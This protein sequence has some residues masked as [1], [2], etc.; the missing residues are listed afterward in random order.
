MGAVVPVWATGTHEQESNAP[1]ARNS[2]DTSLKIDVSG[3]VGRKAERT[4]DQSRRLAMWRILLVA[5]SAATLYDSAS[6]G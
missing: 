6:V 3:L 4:A 5:S 2:I 1:E